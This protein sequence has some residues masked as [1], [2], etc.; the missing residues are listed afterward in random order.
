MPLG[1]GASGSGSENWAASD[2]NC[3]RAGDPGSENIV[4]PGYPNAG[5]FAPQEPRY[6]P[7]GFSGFP[8]TPSGC[9]A[10]FWS[11]T[12]SA[13]PEAHRRIP[14]KKRGTQPAAVTNEGIF[15]TH[16]RGKEKMKKNGSVISWSPHRF[17]SGRET[18][19]SAISRSVSWF[20]RSW[21]ENLSLSI[22]TASSGRILPVER[23]MDASLTMCNPRSI[24]ARRRE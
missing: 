16:M 10:F 3:L 15:A 8:A 7:D 1:P 9:R 6:G 20:F 18:E 22:V 5:G 14:P 4:R 21:P 24:S 2:R 13:V 11:R 12:P 19:P 17:Y 23:A